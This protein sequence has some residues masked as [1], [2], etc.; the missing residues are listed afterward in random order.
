MK[1]GIAVVVAVLSLAAARPAL[2]WDP[3][4]TPA[5]SVGAPTEPSPDPAPFIAPPPGIYYVTDTYVTDV[6]TTNGPRT[7]Y[8][9]ETVHE[10]TGSYARVLGEV[11]TGDAS[12]FDG[13]SFNGRARL[14]DGRQVAGTYY[15]NYVLTESGFVPVSV[16]F[17]QDD[18]ELARQRQ[19][20]TASGGAPSSGAPAMGEPSSG[21]TATVP[22]SE[23]CRASLA[24][25]SSAGSRSAQDEGPRDRREGPTGRI[26][27]GISLRPNGAVLAS[28]EVLRGRP[29]ALW[30]RAFADGRELPVRSWSFLAG[31]A[32]DAEATS[33]SGTT[34][35]RSAWD[36]LAPNGA[37]YQLRFR[38][39]VDA[40]VASNV[41]EADI[42]V[43]VRSPALSE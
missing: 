39:V 4:R 28:F 34:P 5:P 21:T 37:S 35:F 16:V 27:P 22:V 33:G 2:A 26:Q 25:D 9:T 12:V 42:A 17:F 8:S 30:L 14:T 29:V 41:V 18:E 13:T 3:T 15:E 23:C 20:G 31:E 19:Q 11:G 40:A 7:T 1:A 24:P 32:G 36:R 6:V 38:L 10:S 43:V